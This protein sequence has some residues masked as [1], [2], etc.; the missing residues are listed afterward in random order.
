MHLFTPASLSLKKKK[1]RNLFSC[2]RMAWIS[3]SQ[4]FSSCRPPPP[5]PHPYHSQKRFSFI[6]FWCHL[7]LPFP[8]PPIPIFPIPP[9]GAVQ[10]ILRTSDTVIMFEKLSSLFRPV[11]C[12]VKY[13]PFRCKQ[14]Y[15]SSFVAH[16]VMSDG[17]AADSK[18]YSSKGALYNPA[19]RCSCQ[20]WKMKI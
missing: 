20:F 3:D 11:Q 12:S 16:N 15:F 13:I 14:K 4:T 7:R 8:S 1:K 2:C 19:P 17:Y 18:L 9:Q 6:W 10:S 5:G